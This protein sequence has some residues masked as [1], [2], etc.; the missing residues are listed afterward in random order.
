MVG[1]SRNLGEEGTLK[2]CWD[3][4]AIS[5]HSGSAGDNCC[6]IQAAAAGYI[7]CE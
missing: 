7:D 2:S 4:T 6:A 5:D 3:G 1:Y